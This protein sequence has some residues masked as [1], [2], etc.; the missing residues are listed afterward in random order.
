MSE[1]NGWP[2]SSPSGRLLTMTVT[3][4][5]AS[6]ATSCGAIWPL[7]KV[8]SSS[9]RIIV[10]SFGCGVRAP[11]QSVIIEVRLD[12]RVMPGP[13]AVHVGKVKRIAARQ[14]HVAEALTV[15]AGQPAVRPEPVERVLPEHAS[16]SIGIIARRIAVAPDVQEIGRTITRRHILRIE[17]ALGEGICFEL[18]D[19]LPRRGRG[20]RVPIEIEPRRLQRLADLI[21]LVERSGGEDLLHQIL[22]DRLVR[23]IMHRVVR[24]DLRIERPILVELGGEL[25]EIARYV[26]ARKR[27]IGL[28][29]E[30]AV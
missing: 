24:E 1:A 4:C 26:G 22:R 3:P 15:G 11:G 20:Q 12:L 25:D 13:V 29:R 21:A 17:A 23:L 28:R 5:S 30:H 2:S 19:V 7:T 9:W 18:V 27:R 16:P 14:D 6:P 10:T 8:R